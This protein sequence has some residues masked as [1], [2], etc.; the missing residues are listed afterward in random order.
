MRQPER[1]RERPAERER[2]RKR[3]RER[4]REKERLREG[5][6]RQGKKPEDKKWRD[7]WKALDT[8]RLP[9]SDAKK[10][11]F[12]REWAIAEYNEHED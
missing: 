9:G 7:A 1:E 10:M 6:N 5:S 11:A 4:E 8:D 12:R 2:E 3:E